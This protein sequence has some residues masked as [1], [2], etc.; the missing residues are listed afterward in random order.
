MKAS[1]WGSSDHIQGWM[2]TMEVGGADRPAWVG[3]DGAE[4]FRKG[5]PLAALKT[6]TCRENYFGYFF[7]LFYFKYIYIYMS[8][9]R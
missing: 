3:V 5:T 7:F 1:P 2:E 9:G 4:D 8:S 6:K